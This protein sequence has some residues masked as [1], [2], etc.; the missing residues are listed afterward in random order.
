MKKKSPL[1]KA[2]HQKDAV[3]CGFFNPTQPTT[4]YQHADQIETENPRSCNNLPLP[5]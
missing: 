3:Q 4:Q 1:Q 5:R 2:Y